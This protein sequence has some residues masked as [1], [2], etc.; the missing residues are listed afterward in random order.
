MT[1]KIESTCTWVA[2]SEIS[3]NYYAAFI[4]NCDISLTN[5][6]RLIKT[7]LPVLVCHL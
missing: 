7:Q 4:L 1:D 5:I 2:T 6:K 3:D